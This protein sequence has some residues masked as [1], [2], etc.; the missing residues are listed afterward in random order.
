MTNSA[1][2]KLQKTRNIKDQIWSQTKKKAKK[3]KTI[4]I[5]AD[6]ASQPLDVVIQYCK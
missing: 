4:T 2:N 6:A 1:T 3:I 5:V